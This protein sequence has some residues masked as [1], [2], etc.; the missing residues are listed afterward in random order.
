M[1]CL[2]T[3]LHEH[4][5]PKGFF[6]LA[7]FLL[8]GLLATAAGAQSPAGEVGGAAAYQPAKTI[9]DYTR[10]QADGADDFDYATNTLRVE[11][12]T[13]RASDEIYRKG[14][15]LGVS[16]EVNRD[17]YAVVYRIDADGVVEVLWPRSRFDDGFV[18]GG[19]EYALPVT[20]AR[21]LK[22]SANE[23]QGLVEAVVSR[24]PFDLRALEIDFHHEQAAERYDFRVAGDPFLA[25]NEVNFAV[26]GLEDSGEFVVTNYASYYVHQA[27]EHPRYLCNQCHVNDDV[28]YDPYRDECTLTIEYDYSW[29][30][31]WYDRY[32]YYPVYGNPVYVYLDPW[33]WSPWVN[34]WY[35][36]YYRCAPW[37]GWGWGW[38]ACYDWS[39]SPYYYGDCV[40]VYNS[41]HRRYRPLD[42]TRL[43]M[44]DG[45]ATKT[46]EYQRGSAMVRS[47]EV[48]DSKRDAMRS[49]TRVDVARGDVSGRTVAD[50]RYRGEAP[51]TRTRRDFDRT[52][53]DGRGGLRIR[54]NV[55]TG[56]GTRVVGDD[57][58][59]TAAGEGRRAGL[60][61]VASPH[62]SSLNLVGSF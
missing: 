32:G 7:Q 34:Y 57:R 46:R 23:G 1:T 21:E 3:Q 20:G 53:A 12:W 38:S 59:H 16:F 29:Y 54:E 31:G 41:G 8:A 24:Y 48:P 5:R 49:R 26:T 27:V 2:R 47:R 60:V 14:E 43:E 44:R 55:R 28:A 37:Y 62:A 50:T 36:P 13:D 19:H 45:V 39:Y 9:D 35:R 25:M 61:P 22:V 17:A 40:T 15:K 11:V 4:S 18:F 10:S 56:A 30:N 6:A 33:T 51:S 42:R 52:A 58:R